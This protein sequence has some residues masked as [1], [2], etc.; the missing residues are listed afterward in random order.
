[1]AVDLEF[2]I[3]PQVGTVPTLIFCLKK[4][5]ME[6]PLLDLKGGNSLAARFFKLLG[7]TFK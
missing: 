5:D 4:L 1:M 3:P 6:K 2:H 7:D